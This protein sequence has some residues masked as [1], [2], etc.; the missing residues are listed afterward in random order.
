MASPL[1]SSHDDIAAVGT[2]DGTLNHQNVILGIHVND[3]QVAYGD[4]F[5]T[6]VAGHAHAGEHAGGEAGGAD[7]AGRTMKHG[8]V[9]IGAAAEVM[10]LDQAGEPAA[11]AHADP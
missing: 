1:G 7:G 3:L 2:R 9:G 5:G 10:A 11:L 8:T 6:H 4:P